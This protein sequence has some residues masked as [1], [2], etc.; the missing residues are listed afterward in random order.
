MKL[1]ILITTIIELLAGV[2]LFFFADKV[3]DFAEHTAGNLALL[4]MYGAAAIAMGVFGLTVWK[5]FDNETMVSS[6]LITF[7]IFHVGVAIAAWRAA[8]AGVLPDMVTAGLHTLL[9]A[10]TAYF[11]VRKRM[12]K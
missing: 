5:N 1:F 3:P 2:V 11:F 10:I 9:A 8:D 4:K 7:L 6:F 12:G